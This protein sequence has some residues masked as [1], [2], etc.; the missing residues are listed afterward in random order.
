[1]WERNV[2]VNMERGYKYSIQSKN[3]KNAQCAVRKVTVRRECFK[4]GPE[5]K[6]E[7]S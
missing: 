4:W 2:I 7:S 6:I 1:M 3:N 5:L